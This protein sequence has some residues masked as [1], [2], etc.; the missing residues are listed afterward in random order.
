MSNAETALVPMKLRGEVEAMAAPRIDTMLTPIEKAAIILTA[1]GP[2]A[3]QGF[4]RQLGDL[5]MQRFVNTIARIGKID[6]DMLDAVVFEFLE[7]LMTGPDMKGGVEAVRKLLAGILDENQLELLLEGIG[8]DQI[9]SIWGRMNETPPAALAT[10]LAAEHPQTAAVIISELRAE[11]AANVLERLD[12]AY[13][14]M[15]VSRL[16]RVPTFDNVVSTSIQNAIERDFLSVLQRNLS[17][18]RPADLIAGLMNNLSTDVREAFLAHLESQDAEL[19][20]NVIRTMFTFD[21]IAIRVFARD[22]AA[23][24]REVEEEVLLKA[25]KLGLSQNSDT[26]GFIFDNLPRRLSERYVE[27]VGAM[28]PVSAKEGEAAQIEL[29]KVILAQSKAGAIKLI[30]KDAV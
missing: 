20:Q 3:A 1:I 10:L 30:D 22:I 7:A 15:I 21:D 12:R 14:Q 27:D 11:V 24:V 16:S 25:L 4:L 19:A 2:D 29:T 18:R 28:D 5:D 17:K 13:A 9:R 6:Q 23:I 8:R 26:V